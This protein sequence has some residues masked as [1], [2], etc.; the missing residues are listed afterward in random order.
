MTILECLSSNLEKASNTNLDVNKWTYI[1]FPILFLACAVLSCVWFGI[2]FGKK[3]LSSGITVSWLSLNIIFLALSLYLLIIGLVAI[4][5][6]NFP[7][8][9]YNFLDWIGYHAFGIEKNSWVILLILL[10]VFLLTI[11]ILKLINDQSV[12]AKR[13]NELN[14]NLAILKGKIAVEINEL[15]FDTSELSVDELKYLLDEQLEKE[16]LKAKYKNKLERISSKTGTTSIDI[17]TKT[18]LNIDD[19]DKNNKGKLN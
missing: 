12:Q 13:I 11:F 1:G 18:L 10:F 14:R 3:K 2:S 16:K 4:Y 7:Y 9:K 19:T 15:N 8:S 17:N 6:S 5:H